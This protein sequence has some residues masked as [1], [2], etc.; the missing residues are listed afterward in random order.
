MAGFS[1]WQA[2]TTLAGTSMA[3][4]MSVTGN[5]LCKEIGWIVQGSPVLGWMVPGFKGSPG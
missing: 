2:S 1:D 3:D 4:G 5:R